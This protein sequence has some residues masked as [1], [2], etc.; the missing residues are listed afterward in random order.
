MT[1]ERRTARVARW[2][3]MVR[4]APGLCG[5]DGVTGAPSG[6][7]AETS[8]AKVPGQS[9]RWYGGVLGH[10]YWPVRARARLRA[11][12]DPWGARRPSLTERG[13]FAADIC[14][15]VSRAVATPSIEVLPPM[16]FARPLALIVTAVEAQA[17]AISWR[18]RE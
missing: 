2:V 4:W 16:R 14:S 10:R 13:R 5:R 18:A 3:S 8:P 12:A 11:A 7:G 17:A 1:A 15:A 9:G 6:W